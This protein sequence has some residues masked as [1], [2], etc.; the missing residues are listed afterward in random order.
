MNKILEEFKRI[1]TE[2]NKFIDET[3]RK[4]EILLSQAKNKFDSMKNSNKNMN[5]KKLDK[6]YEYLETIK[7]HLKKAINLKEEI[8]SYNAFF[9]KSFQDLILFL[10]I[11]IKEILNKNN[12]TMD[13]EEENENFQDII[14]LAQLT[15]MFAEENMDI[16]KS[17]SN[18]QKQNILMQL[19][20]N[21]NII[22]SNLSPNI[23]I[24]NNI[25][26]NSIIDKLSKVLNH[27]SDYIIFIYNDINS[28]N[29]NNNNDINP[30]ISN[31]LLNSI[32]I[33]NLNINNNINNSKIWKL[34][35]TKNNNQE[36][37]F[38]QSNFKSERNK[39]LKKYPKN[40]SI[41]IYIEKVNNAEKIIK[42]IKYILSYIK[43]KIM[44]YYVITN[45]L[46]CKMVGY[47]YF[48]IFGIGKRKKKII[49]K[50]KNL[51]DNI[52]NK[53]L[54]N[55]INVLIK[56][57]LYDDIDILLKNKFFKLLKNEFLKL[58]DKKE[59][60]NS[61]ININDLINLVKNN[62]HYNFDEDLITKYLN[63]DNIFF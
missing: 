25:K 40:Y 3:N 34:I 11:K 13:D 33:N 18:P 19:K 48:Q 49:Q 29:F 42:L 17:D 38:T 56:A 58:N 46:K 1:K 14:K 12:E 41:K 62:I 53:T 50:I 39:K 22:N 21:L 61:I 6:K 37:T 47:Y 5:N 51:I 45:N 8:Y 35:I 28:I 54:Y 4:G 24:N 57:S 7:M 43:N 32:F 9:N 59:E 15:K 60:N 63:L 2:R 36:I 55:N 16:I 10:D 23:I 44:N 26:N 31:Y 20:E 52:N 27:I 30:Y